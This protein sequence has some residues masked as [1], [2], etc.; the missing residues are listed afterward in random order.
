MVA[1]VAA[2]TVVEAAVAA[3]AEIAAA[4]AAVVGGA[5]VTSSNF[6]IQIL[7]GMVPAETPA[8]AS[9]MELCGC[10]QHET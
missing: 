4:G 7:D 10:R 8:S 2:A 9:A 6:H 1:E 3:I 5:I